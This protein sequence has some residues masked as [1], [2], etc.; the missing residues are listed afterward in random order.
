M[1][2]LV[3]ALFVRLSFVFLKRRTHPLL[4]DVLAALLLQDLIALKINLNKSFLFESSELYESLEHFDI[5]ENGDLVEGEVD[6]L[7]FD[8]IEDVVRH[9]S[10]EV[11]A[12]IDELERCYAANVVDFGDFIM[13]KVDYLQIA[14]GCNVQGDGSNVVVTKIELADAFGRGEMRYFLDLNGVLLASTLLS[15]K[16][17]THH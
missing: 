10:Y 14:C 7:N 8:K 9:F 15:G 4:A 17:A 1:N 6:I 16:V 2:I 13:R 12:E 11:V 5:V 3:A